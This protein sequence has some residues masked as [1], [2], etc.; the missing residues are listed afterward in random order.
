MNRLRLLYY[1]TE[2][3]A[4]LV[5][6]E[7]FQ[8]LGCAVKAFACPL[9]NKEQEEVFRPMICQLV[10]AQK[11]EAIFSFG[12]FPALSDVCE[13]EGILYLAYCAKAP[14]LEMFSRNIGNTCNYFFVADSALAGEFP[15]R[16][17]RKVYYLPLAPV[18]SV[19]T[20]SVDYARQDGI[21][22]AGSLYEDNLYKHFAKLP[23]SVRGFFDGITEAQ[24]HLYGYSLFEELLEDKILEV[25]MQVVSIEQ[26]K[27]NKDKYRYTI[28]HFFLEQQTTKLERS[29]IVGR[30]GEQFGGKFRF[31][32]QEKLESYGR[33]YTGGLLYGEPLAALYHSSA[34]NLNITN[35]AYTCGIPLKVWDILACGGFL[36]SNYQ[37]DFDGLL[38]PGRDFVMYGSLDELAELAGYYLEHNEERGK[39]AREA[40]ERVLAEHNWQRRAESI[41]SVIG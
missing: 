28:Q 23:D 36:L 41:L 11:A 12:Y 10:H 1:Q 26:A 4:N 34:V 25:L 31:Y 27:N 39:M 40:R 2:Y 3:P 16:G 22:F 13:K 18:L 37:A 6:L 32:T 24:V 8:A 33:R 9:A 38:E 35:R 21:S 15:L 20:E 17:A 19:K 7:A 30:M 29:R 14:C 5:C